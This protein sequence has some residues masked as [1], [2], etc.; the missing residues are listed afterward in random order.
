MTRPAAI[1]VLA[2]DPADLAERD[3]VIAVFVD[4]EGGLDA[5]ARRVNKLTRGGVEKARVQGR[6]ARRGRNTRVL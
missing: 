1:R 6:A 5:L 4:P 2:S 3:G